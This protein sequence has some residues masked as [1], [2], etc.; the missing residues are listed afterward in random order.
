M[1]ATGII[2]STTTTG[3]GNLT[4]AQVTGYPRANDYW[5]FGG[6]IPVPYTIVDASATPAKIIEEGFGYLTTDANTWVRAVII[7]TY[8]SA[9]LARFPTAASLAAGTKYL[10]VGLHISA[11]AALQLP[12]KG[13]TVLDVTNRWLFPSNVYDA[14]TGNLTASN[15]N[16]GY[17]IPVRYDFMGKVDAFVF[18]AGS[19]FNLDIALF[20]VDYATFKPRGPALISIANTACTNAQQLKTFTAVVLSPGWYFLYWNQSAAGLST[21]R[22]M[23]LMPQPHFPSGG[24]TATSILLEDPSILVEATLTQGTVPTSPAP[25]NCAQFNGT[26]DQGNQVPTIVLRIS[27]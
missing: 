23:I 27:T 3:T 1:Y 2:E 7:S 25:A 16:R 9:T 22:K 11:T 26:S 8:V 21:T 19:T 13:C 14:S 10:L 20:P 24:Q 12:S 6:N 18:Q 15:N 4:I 5:P 17:Y